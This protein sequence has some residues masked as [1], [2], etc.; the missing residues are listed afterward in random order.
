LIRTISPVPASTSISILWP[1]AFAALDLPNAVVDGDDALGEGHVAHIVDRQ[2]ACCGGG[3]PKRGKAEDNA[4][5]E[6]THG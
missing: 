1:P 3:Q 4:P 2:M 5:Q 6:S